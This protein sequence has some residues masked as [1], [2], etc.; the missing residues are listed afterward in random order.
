MIKVVLSHNHSR[1]HFCF[2]PDSLK[3]V[4]RYIRDTKGI[5][6]FIMERYP[7]ELGPTSEKTVQEVKSGL[8][9]RMNTVFPFSEDTRFD[10]HGLLRLWMIQEMTAFMR[11]EYLIQ[12]G[13][14]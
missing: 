11:E 6:A 14:K 5:S 12:G 8:L 4:Y 13:R 1:G 9:R 3:E 2:L 7:K 10:R